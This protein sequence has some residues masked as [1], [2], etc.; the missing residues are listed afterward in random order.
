MGEYVELETGA[1]RANLFPG[2][3]ERGSITFGVKTGL[4]ISVDQRHGTRIDRHLCL[5][6]LYV[7]IYVHILCNF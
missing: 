5:L 7:F 2:G 6:L 4:V 3:S 1:G